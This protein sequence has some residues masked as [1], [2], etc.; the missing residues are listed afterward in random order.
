MKRHNWHVLLIFGV[1][2]LIMALLLVNIFYII[3]FKTHF[4][5][6]TD[7]EKYSK[8]VGQYTE[9]LQAK[10]G[11]IYDSQQHPL[12][13]DVTSY[14]IIAN[15][16]KQRFNYAG[17]PAHVVDPVF[18][19]QQLAQY[20]KASEQT[21]IGYL[22]RT[23]A[24]Q[25]ELGVAGKDLT[26][27]TKEQI[28]Q[29]NL[30]GIS[31]VKTVSRRYPEGDFASYMLGFA[32]YQET[33]QTIIGEMGLESIFNQTLLGTNG[34][35]KYP[36][37]K[38]T[39]IMLPGAQVETNPEISGQDIYLT[40]NYAAQ[41]W[42]ET[43]LAK[44]MVE[45]NASHAWGGLMELSTGRIL[46]MSSYPSFNP[47][48]VNLSD[49]VNYNTRYLFEPGSTFKAFTYAAALDAGV[50]PTAKYDSS[51]FY[52]DVVDGVM[53]RALKRTKHGAISNALSN[54][55]G[56]LTF[57][58][59][60]VLSSNVAIAE[61]LTNYLKPATFRQYLNDFGFF[62]P[63]G[64]DGYTENAGSLQFNYPIEQ[65]NVGF[66]QGVM[67]TTLQMLQAYSAFFNEGKMLKPYVV[68]MI[69]D[70]TSAEITYL[71]EP[72]V[73][74]QP[75]KAST[76]NQMQALM[77]QVVE[78]NYGTGHYY[79]Q[80]SFGVMG[81][82]GTAQ[83]FTDGSYQKGENLASV[84]LAFPSEAPR[85]LLFY[86]FEAPFTRTM[87]AKSDIV[88]EFIYQIGLEY[89]LINK[90]SIPNPTGPNVELIKTVMPNL[91]NHSTNFSL[92]Q[93]ALNQVEVVI[94]GNGDQ[95]VEQYPQALSE[96]M[97]G[98]KVF[99]KTNQ[100]EVSMPNMQGWS[101]KDV[102]AFWALTQYAVTMDG[103]GWVVNQNIPPDTIILANTEI[104]VR[105]AE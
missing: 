11:T 49:Y 9:I 57:D 82:T 50:Y 73:V 85:F 18:T 93:L 51:I 41:N 59:G 21:L 47:E 37:S 68:E 20:L 31:F 75:I 80:A 102:T 61:L 64:F 46:A 65:I 90:D 74:G 8:N 72:T 22:S 94:I 67:V 48:L 5:S 71:A 32:R 45:K 55:W 12:A 97:S 4:N 2:T 104:T 6:H 3:V 42:L 58:D 34:Y 79:Q 101:R 43:A 66:G 56:M 38:G 28:N 30:P 89:G 96:I 99:L 103:L 69:K 53:K 1:I 10:R 29:L 25:V 26:A 92:K 44:T 78:I 84:V 15:L 39:N 17:E 86:A 40:L 60:F 91:I 105:F 88:N 81:K 35:R 62:Q 98:Q 77:K 52:I 16:D 33:K 83:I 13:L 63:V 7:I 24:L 95:V 36:A 70:P 54:S 19:A 100:A 14:K 27:Q 23:D 76:A 87:H